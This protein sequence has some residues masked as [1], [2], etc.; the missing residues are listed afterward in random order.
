MR[1]LEDTIGPAPPVLI[2]DA[3]F[4]CGD[5]CR[6]L[7]QLYDP[8]TVVHAGGAR[9]CGNCKVNP[10]NQPHHVCANRTQES[11]AGWLLREAERLEQRRIELSAFNIAAE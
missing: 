6:S 8:T 2:T 4:G 5:E 11:Y 1:F 10:S 9:F 3:T 7:G